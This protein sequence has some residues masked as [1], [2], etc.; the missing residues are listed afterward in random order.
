MPRLARVAVTVQSAATSL[1]APALKAMEA[2]ARV[3]NVE[4]QPVAI[5]GPQDFDQALAVLAQRRSDGVH[6]RG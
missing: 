5:K 6:R 2:T 3:L 1:S 4:L